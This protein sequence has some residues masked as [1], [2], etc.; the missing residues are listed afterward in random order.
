MVSGIFLFQFGFAGDHRV[1]LS[2]PE[3]FNHHST[4]LGISKVMSAIITE[5][6]MKIPF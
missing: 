2:E 1:H 4:I 6:L 5:S 3:H